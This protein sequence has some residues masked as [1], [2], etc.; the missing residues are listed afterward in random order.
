LKAAP[1]SV[2]ESIILRDLTVPL[3]L[4]RYELVI[5]TEVAE[6][7]EEEF[8]EIVVDNICE[9][10]KRYIFFTAARPGQG[11]HYHVNEQPHSYWMEKFS[12][13]G[14]E[15]DQD[16]TTQCRSQL[17]QAINSVRWFVDNAMIF[18]LA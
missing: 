13:R 12:R 1:P 6:H 14:V 4:G 17:S 3:R 2:K 11:G 15:L 5:C 18:C 16:L 7:L 10:A 8:A 9:N